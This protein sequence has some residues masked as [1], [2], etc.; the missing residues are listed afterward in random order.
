MHRWVWDL[1]GAP[2]STPG[3]RG[4]RGRGATISQPGRYSVRLTVDGKSYTQPLVVRQD[5]RGVL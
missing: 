3:G 1:R 4:G 5:P 2:A